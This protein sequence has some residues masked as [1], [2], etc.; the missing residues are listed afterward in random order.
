MIIIS[1]VAQTLGFGGISK[2]VDRAAIEGD[3]VKAAPAEIILPEIKDDPILREEAPEISAKAKSYILVEPDS[4]KIFAEKDIHLAV[5]VASTTKIMTAIVSL[6]QYRPT[7]TVVISKKAASQAGSDAGLLY[8]EQLTVHDL[9]KCMLL[10]SG[11]DS[12]YALAEN[13]G[14]V[15]KFVE[16]MNEK[17]LSL[18]MENTKFVDPAGLSDS[19]YSTAYDLYLAAKYAIE[20]KEFSEIVKID[21]ETVSSQNSQV[22][23]KLINTNILITDNFNG[24]IG[25]KTGHTEKSGHCLVSMTDRGGK[26]L[27][28]VILN[29]NIKDS[30][31]PAAEAKKL[32]EWGYENIKFNL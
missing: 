21:Q 25:I 6:E 13:Y 10:N 8:G 14:D 5:P 30:K 32:F 2:E 4:D 9:L 31:A 22:K 17:A 23:H 18:G 16:L 29:S 3:I 1:V 15:E 24:A 20:R 12:A 28:S 26:R 27:I 7:D 11:N 19:G